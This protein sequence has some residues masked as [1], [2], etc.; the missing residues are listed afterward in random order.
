MSDAKRLVLKY[1]DKDEFQANIERAARG[2]PIKWKRTP[3][4]EA[5]ISWIRILR[6]HGV[7]PE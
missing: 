6:R 2:R 3:S 4:V 7:K 1:M 5:E